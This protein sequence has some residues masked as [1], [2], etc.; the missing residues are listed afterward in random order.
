MTK[1]FPKKTYILGGGDSDGT[2]STGTQNE[3]DAARAAGTNVDSQGTDSQ[4]A[5]GTH[6][7]NARVS[8]G[9]TGA[10]Q[11]QTDAG[12]GAA[13]TGSSGA[14]FPTTI[15]G[16]LSPQSTGGQGEDAGNA[17]DADLTVSQGSTGALMGQTDAGSESTNLGA[18]GAVM[19]QSDSGSEAAATGTESEESGNT[20]SANLSLSQGATGTSMAQTETGSESVGTGTSSENAGNEHTANLSVAQGST[21]ASMAQTETG[22][23]T[24]STGTDAGAFGS[25]LVIASGALSTGSSG[26]SQSQ[27]ETGS[28]TVSLGSTGASQSV[29][30]SGTATGYA[31][32]TTEEHTSG[33]NWTNLTNAQ[34]AFNDTPATVASAASPTAADSAHTDLVLQFA[35]G[36]TPS[37]WTRTKVEVLIRHKY[38]CVVGIASTAELLVRATKADGTGAFTILTRST[39]DSRAA[40]A[41]DTVDV[42]TSV[43]GWTEAELADI[44]IRCEAD[45][46]LLIVT[47][48]NASWDVDG[49]HIRTTFS[50]T[51][52][53]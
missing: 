40:Y 8:T 41:T 3:D 44:K 46:D 21:G 12:V 17:H 48:G 32:S 25:A 29:N 52:L 50:R 11:S 38:D 26:A 15:A 14:Q 6:N 18:S 28:E 4:S 53:T 2:V 49:V 19:G 37:G 35:L 31:D 22:T 24:A 42:T 20:H 13:S 10:S 27:T 51:G 47:G 16:S 5:G 45:F 7:A 36:Q 34:G 1:I 33:D 23:D 9:S 43:S 30:T 39:G